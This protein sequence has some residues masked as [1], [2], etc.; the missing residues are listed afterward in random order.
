MNEIDPNRG[1]RMLVT[2]LPCD[3]SVS[4][5]AVPKAPTGEQRATCPQS[6]SRVTCQAA[7]SS[8]PAS[9][10]RSRASTTR[11]R[12]VSAGANESTVTPML[13]SDWLQVR[14]YEPCWNGTEAACGAALHTGHLNNLDYTAC[15]QS[16]PGYCGI[17]YRQ[18]ASIIF[19]TITNYFP[20]CQ[21]DPQAFQLSGLQGDN[22]PVPVNGEAAC[23]DD[24]LYI[25]RGQ[26]LDDVTQKYTEE[27]CGGSSFI[28]RSRIIVR[29]NRNI[30]HQ[31]RFCSVKNRY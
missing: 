24:Y 5:L 4:S 27:R 14:N 9:R 21:A 16:E 15:V 22:V 20:R 29:Q 12:C 30:F 1:W 8:T 13:P 26:H 3:C 18:V 10:A 23:H 17:S 2:Q 6:V 25:P 7:S 19:F 28:M 31:G 11:A